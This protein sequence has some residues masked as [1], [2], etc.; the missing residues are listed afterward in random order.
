VALF[1]EKFN[2]LIVAKVSG[3]MQKWETVYGNGRI[4][5]FLNEKIRMPEA[6][7]KES[8]EEGRAAVAAQF[9]GG[10]LAIEQLSEDRLIA[11]DDRGRDEVGAGA[12]AVQEDGK[13]AL[14]AF[15]NAVLGKCLRSNKMRRSGNGRWTLEAKR[16]QNKRKKNE[17]VDVFAFSNVGP[18]TID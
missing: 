12:A 2:K 17:F 13:G 16:G 18:Y 6:V 1:H 5:T 11:P 3:V 8:K 14:G 10:G 9:V 15:F 7:V 4:G